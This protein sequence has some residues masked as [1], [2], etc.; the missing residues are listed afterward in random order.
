[1]SSYQPTC[2][3]PFC[4]ESHGKK[5]ELYKQI[6]ALYDRHLSEYRKDHSTDIALIKVHSDIS[7]SLD[8]GSMAALVLLDISISFNAIDHSVL[9]RYLEC[10]LGTEYEILV[11]Y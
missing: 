6:N 10:T 5:E 3:L 1:M 7:D 8:E 11:F 2:N 4:Q 9:I